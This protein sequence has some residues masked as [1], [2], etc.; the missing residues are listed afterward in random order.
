M[1]LA[2]VELIFFVEV[3][4]MP[5]LGILVEDSGDSTVMFS[6][7]WAV[8]HRAKGVSA[9]HTALPE[10]NCGAQG[11]GKGQSQSNLSKLSNGIF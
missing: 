7:C 3:C 9:L 4:L 5:C 11:A 1:I 6:C 10:R 2:G 8:L